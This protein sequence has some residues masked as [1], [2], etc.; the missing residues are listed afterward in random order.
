MMAG[1]GAGDG[2]AGERQLCRGHRGSEAGSGGGGARGRPEDLDHDHQDA[3]R[4]DRV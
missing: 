2:G 4:A 3:A 1:V